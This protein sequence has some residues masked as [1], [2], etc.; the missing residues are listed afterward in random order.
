[1]PN[2]RFQPKIGR[3]SQKRGHING[4]AFKLIA[5]EAGKS[6][7]SHVRRASL[8]RRPVAELGRGKG[9]L[10]AL[11]LP[12]PGWRHVVVKARIARHGTSDLGAARAHQTYLQRDGVTPDGRPGQLYD[13]ERDDIDGGAFLARQKGDTYQFRL[14]VSVEDSPQM[15]ELKPFVRDLMAG[16]EHDLHTQLDWVAVDHFNSGHPHTHIIIRGRDDQGQDLVMARHYI[17]HGIRN[18]ARE[19]VTL[20]LGPELEIDRIDKLRRDLTAERFTQLDRQIVE[21]AEGGILTISAMPEAERGWSAYRNGRLK[22]LARMGLAEEKQTGVW[23]ISHE[24]RAHLAPHGR[25]RR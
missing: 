24:P 7:R 18:R 11:L 4:R 5:R 10:H 20:E 16:M 1:M 9:S 3:P 25:A 15:A 12:K 2:D 8:T 14:I 23:S 19:L 6:A 17:S 13:R 21:H 22:V